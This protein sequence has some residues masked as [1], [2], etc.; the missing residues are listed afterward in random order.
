MQEAL[1]EAQ[2]L[3]LWHERVKDGRIRVW[4]DKDQV[5]HFACDGHPS[6]K[7]EVPL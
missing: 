5:L 1:T 7:I 6:C 3:F 4:F 2:V